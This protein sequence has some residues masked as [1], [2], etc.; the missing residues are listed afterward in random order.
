M[1]K[2]SSKLLKYLTLI[3]SIIIILLFIIRWQAISTLK[4]IANA[5]AE[6]YSI[7]LINDVILDSA[8]N[9]N[10]LYTQLYRINRNNN[11][12]IISV[13]NNA[14]ATNYLTTKINA[15]LLANLKERENNNLSIPLG[16]LLGLKV[17]YA[18][19]PN[20]RIKTTPI[21]TSNCKINSYFTDAG[22]NQTRL[23]VYADFNVKITFAIPTYKITK[24][25]NSSVLLYDIII[26]GKVPEIFLS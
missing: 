11:G 5:T 18:I 3:L 13:E 4:N 9:D 10:D 1:S 2:K 23:T 25:T 7:E 14:T 15:T 22:I 17:L 20:I 24:N 21:K 19:G 16:S 12:D 26:V 6:S 8:I